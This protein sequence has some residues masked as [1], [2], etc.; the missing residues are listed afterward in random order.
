M[1]IKNKLRKQFFV[2]SKLN[3]M[4]DLFFFIKRM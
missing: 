3:Y 2:Q 4:C 1:L